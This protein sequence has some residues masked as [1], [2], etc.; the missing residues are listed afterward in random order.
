M[1][2]K[3]SAPEDDRG[4][5]ADKKEKKIQKESSE[6]SEILHCNSCG[7]DVKTGQVVCHN[8]GFKLK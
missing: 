3:T 4:I 1:Q 8:C 7:Y 6:N 5:S 2:Q